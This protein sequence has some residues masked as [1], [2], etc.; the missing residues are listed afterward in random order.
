MTALQPDQHYSLD[1]FRHTWLAEEGDGWRA[2]ILW[3]ATSPTR[4]EVSEVARIHRDLHDGGVT[5]CD[6][7]HYDATRYPTFLEFLRG[8]PHE[9]EITDGGAEMA[10]LNARQGTWYPAWP[11]ECFTVSFD[12]AYLLGFA[13]ACNTAVRMR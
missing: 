7:A 4:H 13:A 12:E 5:G 2:A 3:L 11:K 1:D 6:T 9:R 8:S 10:D